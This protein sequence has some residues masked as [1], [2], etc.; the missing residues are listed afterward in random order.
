MPD[1]PVDVKVPAR[2]SAT[3]PAMP[4][5]PAAVA[6]GA[7]RAS[8]YTP[9]AMINGGSS[10]SPTAASI[11]GSPS[12]PPHGYHGPS[13][14]PSSGSSS[15]S[16]S[17]SSSTSSSA[18]LSLSAASTLGQQQQQHHQSQHHHHHHHHN[19][20][21]NQQHHHHHQQQQH[22]PQ[23][24][25]HQQPVPAACGAR[26]LSK[27]KRFLATL[28]QFGS[29]ISPEIGER[30]RGLVLGLVN[31][32]V[33]IEE[34]H[35]KLQEATNFPL[36]PFVIP[37][38]K[39]NLPLLQRE[40]LQCARTA[41]LSPAQYLAQ[42]QFLL[43]DVGIPPAPPAAPLAPG[44]GTSSHGGGTM[45]G[46]HNHHH[47]HHH[48]HHQQ[49]HQQHH[50]QHHP[51]HHGTATMPHHHHQQ[52][53]QHHHHQ[54]QHQQQ[55]PSP[56]DSA[57]PLLEVNENGKRSLSDRGSRE[58]GLGHDAPSSK[59]LCP[60][61]A[62]PPPS[63]GG[64]G[65][66]G[67]PLNGSAASSHNALAALASPL[68]PP[69]APSGGG[70]GVAGSTAQR[71][72]SSG[73]VHGQSAVVGLSQPATLYSLG[74]GSGGHH[75]R[76]EEMAHG[77]RAA[78]NIPHGGAAMA[79]SPSGLYRD[80][81]C[82][83]R[84]HRERHHSLALP[85][86]RPEEVIDHRL[87]E[88]EWAEEW[89]HLDHLL[90][91]ILEMVEKTRRAISVLRRCQETDRQE[92][93]RWVRRCCSEEAAD[94]PG[95]SASAGPVGKKNGLGHV[96]VGGSGSTLGSVSGIS[97]QQQQQ[98]Q[99]LA[100][101]VAA[102]PSGGLASTASLLLLDTHQEF[103]SRPGTRYMP[104]DIWR[105]AEEAV[106]DVKRR[107]MSELQKAVSDAERQARSTIEGERARMERA[108]A[109]AKRQAASDAIAI[110]ARQDD[111]SES[112]WN[113]G[114]KASETCSGCNTAR[115]CG[116]FCQHKDWERHHHVCGQR[117]QQ[118]Q[119]Q[120]EQHRH[121]QQQQQQQPKVE[122]SPQPSADLIVQTAGSVKGGGG[123][124]G[125]GSS[126]SSSGG[127]GGKAQEAVDKASA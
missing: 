26:Q 15:S 50:H 89:K 60:P 8:T 127:G 34:F 70:A 24:Q 42:N 94:P 126:S 6:Q 76:A 31:S 57:E 107:A 86:S 81:A 21:S 69:L 14:S 5:P 109:D 44:A 35:S 22:H 20:H 75:R 100:P 106:N 88:R 110:V 117:Q 47:Q 38:L 85:V 73:G 78:H 82:E 9:T 77:G 48:Q 124:G 121:H 45:A 97:K 125:G 10:H 32:S 118:Q 39:A 72:A 123:G 1:S 41:K 96:A 46:S 71:P 104:E 93:A 53:Q 113:C 84:E 36:R 92:L 23:Q 65:G 101:V 37:F 59:R 116:A 66:N 61:L 90:S 3:P 114:R 119:P 13:P 99:Q 28:Q 79:A 12:S 103:L 58:N 40:L 83:M 120:K 25:H 52:Q 122:P 43:L 2:S 95:A 108:L 74:G 4:P 55:S 62:P 49:H 7:P 98:L 18:S 19:H 27:L 87:T 30:V 68:A 63:I 115:Y 11:G 54:Q 105:K 17:L 102:V 29:D 111:S 33:T 80:A 112:C 67:P 64:G 91:C 16:S 51:P 56:F